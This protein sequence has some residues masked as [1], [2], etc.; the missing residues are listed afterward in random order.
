MDIMKNKYIIRVF[1]LLIMITCV[2]KL[3]GIEYISDTLV[4][5]LMGYVTGLITLNNVEKKWKTKS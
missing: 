1:I 3:C 4:L 2:M 5:G